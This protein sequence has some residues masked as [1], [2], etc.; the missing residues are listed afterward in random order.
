MKMI[1]SM[2]R[3]GAA[4]AGNFFDEEFLANPY[5]RLAYLRELG[6]VVPFQKLFGRQLWLVSQ[7]DEAV[8]VLK[9]TRFSVNWRKLFSSPLAWV[10]QRMSSSSGR[11][12]LSQSM[13]GVDEPDH[14]RLRG[15][16]A[17]AFT[18]RFIDN[19]R[20]RIQFLADELLD[21]VQ[22]RSEMDLVNEYAY[23]LPIN[24]I[25]EMLGIAEDAREDIK[26][27][28]QA[29][30]GA[31]MATGAG[32]RYGDLTAFADFVRKLA[33]EKRRNPG[34]DLTSQLVRTE[35]AGDRLSEQ[36][37]QSMV[38]LLI[39]AGH[40]TTSNLIG[41]GALALLDHPEQLARLKADPSLVPQAV[42]EMLRFASPVT[43]PA[44]RFATTDV[45][46]GGQL[47]R[48]GEVVMVLL[49]SANQDVKQFVAPE[50][51]NLTREEN[52]HIAFGQGIHYC[53]G[54]PLARLEGDVAFTSLLRRMP[55]L[56]LNVPREQVQFRGALNLRGLVSLPVAF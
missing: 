14:S 54:A 55:G 13:I 38:Q 18:P 51:L 16:V 49:T 43:S 52:R 27:W 3:Q 20:P 48:K 41:L 2:K 7:Y 37:L 1:S 19:L 46:V 17:K 45:E 33:A 35:E 34:D 36:E 50:G 5:P 47:I 25:S 24:V 29:I 53:L 32:S 21:K 10:A 26:G 30:T 40:E 44:P 15:L 31:N 39:F 6:A 28:S 11:F 23:P 12:D 42:E 22:D 8:S 4:S 9:D 56:R